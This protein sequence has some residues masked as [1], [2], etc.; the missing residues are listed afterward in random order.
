MS[1]LFHEVV[2]DEWI[3]KIF[4][5]AALCPQHTF[6][7]LTKRPARMVRYFADLEERRKAIANEV[8]K[9]QVSY[10]LHQR[11]V[12]AIRL[13]LPLA[14]V[15]LGVTAENQRTA[16]ERIPLLLQVPAVV[17]FLSCEPLLERI[18]IPKD[19]FDAANY[20]PHCDKTGAIIKDGIHAR[21]DRSVPKY[22]VIVGGESGPG[23]RPCH[24][25]WLS[26]IVQQCKEFD[27][28]VFVKQ[29][30]SN[31]WQESKISQFLSDEPSTA[32]SKA[33]R[34]GANFEQ[35]PLNLQIRQIP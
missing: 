7:I 13:S 30:G 27:V 21:C 28:P 16:N 5:V 6:Q 10:S 35:F 26:S 17:K 3:D 15:W 19:F 20:C 12:N 23:A 18:D 34:K 1:D 9:I 8:L 33:D 29:L 11:K 22:W 31:A 4:A 24:T 25:S 14:N 32:R 2:L